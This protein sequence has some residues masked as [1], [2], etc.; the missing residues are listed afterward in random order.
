[1]V[2]TSKRP[3]HGKENRAGVSLDREVDREISRGGGR[4]P[5]FLR[6]K[7]ARGMLDVKSLIPPSAH[8]STRA[9]SKFFL[10]VPH[11]PDRAGILACVSRVEMLPTSQRSRPNPTTQ[12]D[13]PP[14]SHTPSESRAISVHVLLFL[15]QA[16]SNASL[17]RKR[18]RVTSE[19]G[20][21]SSTSSSSSQPTANSQAAR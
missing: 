12:R 10:S 9:P 4:G 1:M 3:R 11:V 5:A 15:N 6:Q 18:S 16:H 14:P 19:E 2:Q 13:A 21:A 20:T 7:I 8:P 17:L